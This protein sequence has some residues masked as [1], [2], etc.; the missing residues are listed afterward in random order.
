MPRGAPFRLASRLRP[1]PPRR[2]LPLLAAALLLAAPG[3]ARAGNDLGLEVG[4]V[5]RIGGTVFVS[6]DVSDPFTPRLE[7]TLLQGMPAHVAFEVGVWKKRTFWFDKLLV[8]IRSE[9][10]I[11]YDTVG[12]TFRI[13]SGTSPPRQATVPSLDSL[14]TRLFTQRRLPLVL[15]SALDSTATYYVSVRVT[16]RPLSPEDLTE[17][18][19][20]LTG[21]GKGEGGRGLPDYLLGLAVSLSGLGDHTA[22]AKSDRFV[23]EELG[24]DR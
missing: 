17:V 13:R 8:A 21:G 15:A 12:R 22:I 18:Q 14:E 20:W 19:D 3:A 4:P 9:H 1:A 16:I 5:E 10:Q 24:E 11:V 23:P 6:Y 2:G 7:E